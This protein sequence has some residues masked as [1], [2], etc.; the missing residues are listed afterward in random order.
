[1]SNDSVSPHATWAKRLLALLLWSTMA[2]VFG[3]TGWLF[4]LEPLVI[5]VGNWQQARDYKPVQAKVVTRDGKAD[6]G[7]AASWLAASYELDGK[8]YYA[9]RL[10]V[11]EDDAPD[12]RS[13][14]AIVKTLEASRGDGKTV[15][16]WV[17]P[18]KPEIALVSR[19]LPLQSLWG[20]APFGIGFAVIALAG[21]AGA[22]GALFNFRYYRKLYD[23][24]G[25]W[26]FSA[27]WCG[28]IFPIF[29]LVST[30]SDI[31]FF[32]VMFL[33]FFALIGILL[34]WGAISASIKGGGSPIQVG[35]TGRSR[36]PASA[37][38][39]TGGKAKKM[40]ANVKRGGIGGHG[41]D[42]DKS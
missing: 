39:T 2:L 5:A 25:M 13:N 17:S 20:R 41:G 12:E 15:T 35:T 27:V 11:L 1:M 8:T 4:G 14:A 3:F 16:V 26:G 29:W 32:V 37:L 42:F 30:Q 7:S 36:L 24:A 21:L 34:L 38:K 6:D 19:D 40:D 28:F 10:S 18:R 9:E 23:A 31:E 22:I 33:G